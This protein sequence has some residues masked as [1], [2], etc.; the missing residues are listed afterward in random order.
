MISECRVGYKTHPYLSQ[1]R[2]A[3][4]GSIIEMRFPNNNIHNLRIKNE[5]DGGNYDGENVGFSSL[6]PAGLHSEDPLGKRKRNLQIIKL[7]VFS[8]KI[9]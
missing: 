2:S 9:Y 1:R 3:L 8:I 4:Q 7:Q 5:E 6:M